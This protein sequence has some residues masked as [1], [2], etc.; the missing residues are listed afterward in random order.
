MGEKEAKSMKELHS[1]F[2]CYGGCLAAIAM[3]M[4]GNSACIFYISTVW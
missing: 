3:A 4:I 1:F 2:L